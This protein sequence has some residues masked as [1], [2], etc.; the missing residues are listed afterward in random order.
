MAERRPV[1]I[2]PPMRTR[3]ARFAA[4]TGVALLVSSLVVTGCAVGGGSLVDVVAVTSVSVSPASLTVVA[5]GQ[6]SAL[7]ATV[8]VTG[9]AST[10][11][12]WVSSDPATATVLGNGTSASVVGLKA[13][14]VR[15]T[16]TSVYD[17]TKSGGTDVTVAPGA[18]VSIALSAATNSVVTQN[19][20]QVQAVGRDAA[21]SAIT[22]LTLSWSSSNTQVATV[23]AS[24]LVTGVSPGN[25]TIS[26]TSGAITSNAL[27]LSVVTAQVASITLSTAATAIVAFA[28]APVQAVARDAAG[29]T[30]NG[31][32]LSWI[33]GNPLIA[34][35]SS[36]GVVTGKNPGTVTI[37]AAAG[38]VVS[39]GLTFTVTNPPVATITVSAASATVLAFSTLQVQAVAKDAAGNTLSSV[40]L[41][42]TS[43]N[44]AVATV[45]T[46]GF[47]TGASPGA[48]NITASSGGVTS[49]ALA[50]TVANPPI[51]T[52]TVSAPAAQVAVNATLQAT[53]VARDASGNA[54]VGVAFTWA[55]SNPL[56]AAVSA[57]G[58]VT[59]K[60]TGTVNITATSGS[61][62]SNNYVVTVTP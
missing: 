61:L 59:G 48:V 21:G 29:A 28:P 62:I 31:A 44:T 10:A 8:A 35:V 25:V 1:N 24:G 53:A 50:L 3:P 30:I 4:R 52:I 16:A 49:N 7:V 33:S 39:N 19:T 26:A 54:L 51:V 17:P 14:T 22:N 55:S 15:I 46:S 18:L 20:L 32:V 42:W 58:L 27:Q 41:T 38:S 9:S 60:L 13:G 34:T 36:T 11:L 40:P 43:S 47:V 37:T 23:S 12:N 57:T 56:I 5:G 2:D 6:G 45:S